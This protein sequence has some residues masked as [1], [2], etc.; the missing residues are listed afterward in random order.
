MAKVKITG[1][2]SGTGIFTVT[3]PN[4]N[5]DRTIT[6]PDGTGTLAF[7]TGDDDKLPLAGGTMTGA[8]NITLADN[9]D[10]LTLTSTDADASVGPNL[11]L[12]RNSASPADWDTVG[13]VEWE[14]RNDNSQD[15]VYGQIKLEA[16]DVSDG[17]EDGNLMFSVMRDGTLRNAMQ[18][19]S[20][21]IVIN[22]DS[23]DIDFRV[24]SDNDTNALF[25]QGSNGNVG[26]GIGA[27]IAPLES[28]ITTGGGYGESNFL[29]TCFSATDAHGP[30][31]TFRKSSSSTLGTHAATTS[32]DCLGVIQFSG[33]DD[34]NA[35]EDG[36]WI[37]AFQTGTGVAAGL[38][39][40]LKFYT[41]NPG[42][43]GASQERLEI[44]HDGRGVSQFTARCGC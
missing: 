27:P 3:A 26:I 22:Q 44:T 12:Y 23:Q 25:V 19:Y 13:A 5:T 40:N 38:P 15:V 42:G 18:L 17:A 14:G 35:W 21:E 10:Q 43:D 8:L 24:E 36:S 16:G 39:S 2:A 4:S 20:D 33:S 29:A 32:G 41:S 30:C 28:A 9:T 11:R 7:T 34:G 37:R 6:L 1:H 31:L